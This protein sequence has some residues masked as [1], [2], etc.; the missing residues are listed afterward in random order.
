MTYHI[1]A[2]ERRAATQVFRDMGVA[3]IIYLP[4]VLGG[5]LAIKYLDPPQWVAAL[6]AVAPLGPAL[7]I[8]RAQLRYTR[9][10]DELHRRIHSEAMMIA[11]IVVAFVTLGYGLLEDLAGFPHVSL[12]WVFPALCVVWSVANIFV[13]RKYL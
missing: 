9:S 4:T 3:A 5:A 2:A 13:R 1:D 6:L 12:L 11:A 10:L 7:L 8:L